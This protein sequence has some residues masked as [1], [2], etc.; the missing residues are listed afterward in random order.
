MEEV[1]AAGTGRERAG[2]RATPR[3]LWDPRHCNSAEVSGA[4]GSERQGASRGREDYRTRVGA[5]PVRASRTLN[6]EATWRCVK[7]VACGVTSVQSNFFSERFWVGG[8]FHTPPCCCNWRPDAP[9]P[10]RALPLTPQAALFLSRYPCPAS[11]SE[12][13]DRPLEGKR[14]PGNPLVEG[15]QDQPGQ[16]SQPQ[17]FSQPCAS[18]LTPSCWSVSAFQQA[19]LLGLGALLY[20]GSELAGRACSQVPQIWPGWCPSGGVGRGQ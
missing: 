12:S 8:C 2:G 5:V 11:V 15:L 13:G 10:S 14:Y 18:P 4:R 16:D 3:S 19:V 9:S 20:V 17:G 6:I 1:S 7:D